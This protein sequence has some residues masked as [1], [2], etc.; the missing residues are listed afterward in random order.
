VGTA[1]MHNVVSVDGFVADENDDVGPLH[2]WQVVRLGIPRHALSA[3]FERSMSTKAGPF[4]IQITEWSG[5]RGSNSRPL[6]WQGTVPILY[7]GGVE[8][9]L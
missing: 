7:S 4:R 6:P 8:T 1:I 5:R 2:D 3:S 9:G